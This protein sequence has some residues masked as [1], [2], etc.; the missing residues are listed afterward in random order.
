[1]KKITSEIDNQISELGSLKNIFGNTKT[2]RFEG[3][4]SLDKIDSKIKSNQRAYYFNLVLS[5]LLGGLLYAAGFAQ[6]F[7]FNIIDLSKSGILIMMAVLV[8]LT[9]A[10]TKMDLMRLKMIKHLLVLKHM[11]GQE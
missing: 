3:F 1:M 2:N 6:A 5:V 11:I 7:D 10:R 4:V 8:I 9:T